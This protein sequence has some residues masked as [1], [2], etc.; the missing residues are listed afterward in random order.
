M[1]CIMFYTKVFSVLRNPRDYLLSLKPRSKCFQ[2]DRG[3]SDYQSRQT[4]KDDLSLT[5]F[6]GPCTLTMF[7]RNVLTKAFLLWNKGVL[8]LK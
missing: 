5:V 6:L 1:L 3:D 8:F 2:H 4:S 7:L